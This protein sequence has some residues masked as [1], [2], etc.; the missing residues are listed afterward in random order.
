MSSEKWTNGA[1]TFEMKASDEV[2]V[3]LDDM[4]CGMQR[5]VDMSTWA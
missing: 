1:R 5:V 3:R 4:G 2:R